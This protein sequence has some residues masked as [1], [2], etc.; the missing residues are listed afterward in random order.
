MCA[1]QLLLARDVEVNNKWANGLTF[2]H[3]A[4]IKGDAKLSE[5]LVEYG[6]LLNVQC[7]ARQL[8]LRVIAHPDEHIT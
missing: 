1:V 7:D 8:S 5:M 2:L 6:A 4:A 3:I